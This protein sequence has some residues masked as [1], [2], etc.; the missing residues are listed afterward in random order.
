[1]GTY[2][3]VFGAVERYR[4]TAKKTKKKDAAPGAH[5]PTDAPVVTGTPPVVKAPVIAPVAGGPSPAVTAPVT[6][7]ASG[8]AV[9][10][11]N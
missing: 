3:S 10:L 8:A 2:D 6:N 7:G 9:S 1:M 5:P 11:P 4:Y